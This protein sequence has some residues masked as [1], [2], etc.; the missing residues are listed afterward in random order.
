MRAIGDGGEPKEPGDRDHFGQNLC[1]SFR[2]E[3][4][5]GRIVEAA[6]TIVDARW[7]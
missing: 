6:Q 1:E 7:G 4:H 2:G 3:N 5:L